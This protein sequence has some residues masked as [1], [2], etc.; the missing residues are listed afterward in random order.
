MLNS[1]ASRLAVMILLAIIGIAVINRESASASTAPGRACSVQVA[2]I[3]TTPAEPVATVQKIKSV[4]TVKAVIPATSTT[5]ATHRFQLVSHRK[6]K[7]MMLEVTGYTS[8][9]SQ[10]DG[11]P[12]IG[13]HLINLC[14]RKARGE[15]LCASNVFRIGTRVHVE[16]LGTCTV[17]DHMNDRYQ[18][19][20]DWYFGQDSQGSKTKRKRA[21]NIGRR[22][23][24]VTIVSTP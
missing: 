18:R 13:S 5:K 3:V 9:K 14:A 21:M 22:D 4:K 20:I 10:T 23:R 1:A 7:T 24:K 15:S 11:D 17:A 16:G 2:P 12:C 19:N 8:T 6:G